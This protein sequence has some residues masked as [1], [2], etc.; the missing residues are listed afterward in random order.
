MLNLPIAKCLGTCH[1]LFEVVERT[2]PKDDITWRCCLLRLSVFNSVS[3]SDTFIGGWDHYFKSSHRH[4][5]DKKSQHS[6]IRGKTLL[7]S[8]SFS[9]PIQQQ[10]VPG[11]FVHFRTAGATAKLRTWTRIDWRT[12]RVR[13][14]SPE[15]LVCN[16]DSSRLVS[17]LTSW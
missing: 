5:S 8:N 9:K 13:I 4:F 15:L 6:N 3:R 17:S 11:Q 2:R 7:L 14:P 10:R 1:T 12:Q 16:R